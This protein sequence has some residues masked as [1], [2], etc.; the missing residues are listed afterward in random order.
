MA[1]PAP[2]APK[3]P[4]NAAPI[5]SPSNPAIETPHTGS[6]IKNTKLSGE[7]KEKLLTKAKKAQDLTHILKKV[8]VLFLILTAGGFL[9]A[10]FSLDPANKVL[11]LFGMQ[12]NVGM[13][14]K[15]LEKKEKKLKAEKKT[16]EGKI[17]KMKQQIETKVFSQFSEEI[18]T[19]RNKQLRWFDTTTAEGKTE[20]GMVN[21]LGRLEEYFN[22]RKYSDP[23]KIISGRRGQITVK[24]IS[25]SRDGLSASAETTQ[26][27]GKLFFLNVEFSKMV[28]AFPFFKDAEIR[29]FT[30]KKNKDE[31]DAMNVSVKAEIQLP[32]EEDPADTA[33]E[34]YENWLKK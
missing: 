28:N 30:R 6:T 10:K 13:K 3:A 12:E 1:T 16:T 14:N 22:S 7:E 11:S 18:G 29:T 17:N 23:Q 19:L 26:L 8:F 20:Y 32:D 27:F 2:L 5:V 9:W 25:V 34:E 31:D 21:A 4:K 33:F 24:N 15:S